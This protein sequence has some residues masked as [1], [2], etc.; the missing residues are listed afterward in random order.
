M[1]RRK[2]KIKLI[3]IFVFL[4]LAT[5]AY[6]LTY[7]IKTQLVSVTTIAT[8]L[9]T[10][11]LVG[12][13]YILITN[14]DTT[15]TIYIGSSTVTVSGATTGTPLL[16]SESYYGEWKSNINIYGIISSGSCNAIIEEGK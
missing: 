2:T 1:A 14:I 8:K 15:K 16:P 9:P 6:S 12:R 4:L 10:T 7:Q 11:P 13:E 5:T 3:L